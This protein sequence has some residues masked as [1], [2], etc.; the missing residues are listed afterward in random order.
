MTRDELRRWGVLR[1]DIEEALEVGASTL[2]LTIHL[3]EVEMT[4][5]EQEGR[6]IA[7]DYSAM[8]RRRMAQEGRALADGS[9]PIANCA[10]AADAIR[11]V[12]RCKARHQGQ[13]LQHIQNRAR[14]FA[15]EG[16]IFEGWT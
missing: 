7:S 13:A 1:S 14:A 2:P 16:K 10:D 6:K 8:A 12:P 3:N 9:F 4:R 11:A 5:L 15:C